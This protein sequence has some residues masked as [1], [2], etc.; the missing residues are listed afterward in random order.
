DGRR[1]PLPLKKYHYHYHYQLVADRAS[2]STTDRAHASYPPSVRLAG[3]E[4]D[5]GGF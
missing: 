3:G 5:G 2:N 4:K 1:L